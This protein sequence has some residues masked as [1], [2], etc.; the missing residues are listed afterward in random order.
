[1]MVQV[2]GERRMFFG[3]TLNHNQISKIKT[4]IFKRKNI[5]VPA[6]EEIAERETYEAQETS[7]TMISA[8]NSCAPAGHRLVQTFSR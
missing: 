8:K 5:T 6:N 7:F 4:G 2:R 3:D 1:M